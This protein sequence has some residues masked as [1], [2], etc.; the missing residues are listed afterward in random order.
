MSSILPSSFTFGVDQSGQQPSQQQALHQIINHNGSYISKPTLR[1]K[2]SKRRLSEEMNSDEENTGRSSRS[3]PKRLSPPVRTALASS[4]NRHKKLRGQEIRGQPLPLKRVI[5]TLDKSQLENLV[6]SLLETR[7]DITPDV[8]NSVPKVSV[9]AVLNMLNERIESL[10]AGLPYKVE[11]KSDYAY[12]RVKHLVAEFFEAVSD[13][14]LNFLPPVE[15]EIMN[16]LV[17]LYEFLTKIY[18]RMPGFSNIEYRYYQKIIIEKFN[19]IFFDVFTLFLAEKKTNILILI[20]DN[21]LEKLKEINEV[22]ENMF[23]GVYDF[24]REEIDNYSRGGSLR[25]EGSDFEPEIRLQGL[26]S[27]LNFSSD[28]SPLQGASSGE[29]YGKYRI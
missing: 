11:P 22:N 4:L 3:S 1:S 19:M 17:F 2:R 8:L 5:Q 26:S 29:V 25:S 9:D 21:W 14:V 6:G 12:L 13:Y 28:N 7:P 15:T 10:V 27:L 20:N 18:N 16:S 23:D 24:V